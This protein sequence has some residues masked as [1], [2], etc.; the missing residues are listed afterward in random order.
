M[1]GLPEADLADF[2][3]R[4]VE[5]ISVAID[6]ARG[7]AASRELRELFARVLADAAPRARETT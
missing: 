7:I 5:L 4:A 2:H 1:L 3:R 6:P